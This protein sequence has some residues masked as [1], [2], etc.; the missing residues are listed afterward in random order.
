MELTG[1]RPL[2]Q[3]A[4]HD[5]RLTLPSGSVQP[6]M[7]LLGPRTSAPDALERARD[8]SRIALTLRH[9]GVIRLVSVVRFQDRIAWCYEPVDGLGLVHLANREDLGGMGARAAA[10][11]VAQVAEVLLALGGPGLH[12]PGPHFAD[13]LLQADG[14]VRVLGFAGPFPQDPSMVPP[15][16][17]A[18]EPGTV[19]RLGV[20]LAGLLGGSTPSPAADANAHEIVVRRALIR[21]MSRPGPV[22]SD[23]YG[24]WIRHM[25][26]WAPAERPPLSSVPA[27]LRSVGWATGGPGLAEWAARAV[28]E[29]GASVLA[30]SGE[31]SLPVDD[32]LSDPGELIA[33]AESG[34]PPPRRRR[35]TTATP[36][37]EP[38]FGEFSERIDDVT[39]EATLDPDRDRVLQR[40]RSAKPSPNILPIDIGPPAEALKKRPPT[41]PPGF[42]QGGDDEE[43]DDHGSTEPTQRAWKVD[44]RLA[45]G[46]GGAVV[47]LVILA[48]VFLAY[49]V[50]GPAD[51]VSPAEGAPKLRDTIAP[52]PVGGTVPRTRPVV[53]SPDRFGGSE[54]ADTDAPGVTAEVLFRLAGET[55]SRIYVSC[56]PHVVTQQGMGQVLLDVTVGD[57]CEVGTKTPD[58]RPLRVR[59]LVVSGTATFACFPNWEPTCTSV[60]D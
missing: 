29:V 4:G 52:G 13:L 16:A 40:G 53:P 15:H 1:A 11:L 33:I 19:Y 47:G 49:L 31:H 5:G 27:G 17:D 23:R 55:R 24:Q 39:Q 20:L 7:V 37:S 44:P 54:D 22:L 10:E 50:W 32:D 41:L 43:D 51:R 25:L 42:L 2:W 45:L 28:P 48:L 26:A 6:V 3:G 38:P 56:E 58:G 30:R 46:W 35:D 57:L 34:P 12:H 18:V 59:D 36:T 9:P 14:H 60:S 21:A 8:A